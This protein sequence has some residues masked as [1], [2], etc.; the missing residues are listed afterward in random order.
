[1][2][3]IDI[4]KALYRHRRLAEK[5]DP[6]YSQ[7]KAAKWIIGFMSLFIIAYLMFFAVIFALAVNSSRNTT[8]L[9]MMLGI[10]PFVMAVDFGVRWLSQQTP[11]QIIKPYILLPLPRYACINTFIFRSLFN[12]GNT[13]WLAMLLPYCLMSVFFAYGLGSCL[14]LICMFMILVLADSQWYSIVRTL[15]LNHQLWWLLPLGVYALVFS[16]LYFSFDEFFDFYSHIGTLLDKGSLLPLAAALLLLAALTAVNRKLQYDNVMAEIG[17]APKATTIKHVSEFSFLNSYGEIGEYLKLEIKSLLRNKN[18]RKSF[19][20]ATVLVVL[21]TLICTFSDVYDGVGMTNFW[22]LYNLVVYASMLLIKVMG[23]EGNYIDALMVH[24]ENILSL[25]RAK[26]IF[27]CGLILVPTLLLMPT[28]IMG[29]WTLWMIL[30]YALF[31][32]GFQYFVI[33]QM[34]VYNKTSIPLNTKFT[35]KNGVE[36]NYL[37]IVISLS[38]FIVPITFI[39]I[40]Q[41]FLS[42]MVAYGIMAVIGLSFVI[43]NKLWIRNIYTRLMA[44]RYENMEGFRSSR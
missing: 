18:P 43:T 34:A 23:N 29:K 6:M 16:P 2:N 27:F 20:S 35:S 3:K 32:I 21:I 12:S 19:I 7:N 26:Y 41:S 25:L 37:Q 10:M 31:T 28:V 33:F 36:N 5:R 42:E 30:S 8:A 13:I 4:F 17:R 38:V 22:C 11:S 44:R 9:E 40:L 15:V 24:K 14:L 1:M 39:E